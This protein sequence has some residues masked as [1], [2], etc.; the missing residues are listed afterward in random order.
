MRGVKGDEAMSKRKIAALTAAL[1]C[2]LLLVGQVAA[3][4]SD[5]YAVN[6]D[7]IGGGGE[8]IASTNFALNATVGQ[9]AI[10]LKSSASHGLCTGYWCGAAVEA[11]V[12]VPLVLRDHS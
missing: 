7:V 9:G 10:G 3:M 12:F 1:L 6:W 11:K 5:D 2:L 4:G 8:P